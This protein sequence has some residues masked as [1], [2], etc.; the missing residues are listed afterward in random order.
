MFRVRK[1]KDTRFIAKV[2][3]IL[4]KGRLKVNPGTVIYLGDNDIDDGINI[5]NL[6]KNQG[7]VP[8]KSQKQ[9]DEIKEEWDTKGKARRESIR[10]GNIRARRQT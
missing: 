1:L 5:E 4:N 7:I 9:A 2:Q 6:L 8:F 3:L 10:T